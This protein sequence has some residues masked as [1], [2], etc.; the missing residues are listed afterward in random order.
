M[1]VPVP[2]AMRQV[3]QQQG[4][5]GLR[6]KACLTG[7][8]L[9]LAWSTRIAQR[10]TLL[11]GQLLTRDNTAACTVSC[12]P[13]SRAHSRQLCSKVAFSTDRTPAGA[14]AREDRSVKERLEVR[15]HPLDDDTGLLVESLGHGK[16]ISTSVT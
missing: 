5:R 9:S 12:K 7:G 14:G 15:L 13:I 11:N 10:G 16:Y 6:A 3:R 1:P 2:M 8:L 4:W